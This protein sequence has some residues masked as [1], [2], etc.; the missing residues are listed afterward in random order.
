[1]LHVASFTLVVLLVG[2]PAL[3]DPELPPEIKE[4]LKA[5]IKYYGGISSFLAAETLDIDV[6]MGKNLDKTSDVSEPL[7]AFISNVGIGLDSVADENEP[8]VVANPTNE[9]HLVAGSHY[10]SRGF[11]PSCVA[12]NSLDSGKTWSAPIPMPQL[13]NGRCSDPVLAFSPDGSRVYYAYMDI[14]QYFNWLQYFS[15]LDIVVDYS[16][17]GGQTWVGPIVALDG[18]PTTYDFTTGIYTPGFQYDKNWIG[19]HVAV[20]DDRFIFGIW[21]EQRHQTSIFAF[22]DNVF[23]DIIYNP[24]QDD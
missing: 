5:N 20:D 18:A 3:A 16:D 19:T 24:F 7:P 21:T 15:D 2:A 22:E 6:I 8:T 11:G 1:M 4:Q 10:I 17:D 23:G 14:K 9:Y 12:Y 13:P